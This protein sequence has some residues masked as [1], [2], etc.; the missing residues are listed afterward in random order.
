MAKII[1]RNEVGKLIAIE[2]IPVDLV[3]EVR[4]YDVQS[5]PAQLLSRDDDGR[6]CEVK[7]W[8]A[9]NSSSSALAVLRDRDSNGTLRRSIG[10]PLSLVLERTTVREKSHFHTTGPTLQ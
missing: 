1:V 4:N 9:R 5:V 10:R 8:R 2:R 3:V 7:E 6:R